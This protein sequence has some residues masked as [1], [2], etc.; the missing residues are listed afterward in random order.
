MTYHVALCGLTAR[1]ARLLRSAS[2]REKAAEALADGLVAA[3]A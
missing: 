2:F 1:D 3:L